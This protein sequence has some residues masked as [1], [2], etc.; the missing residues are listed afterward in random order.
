[1]RMH[2]PAVFVVAGA[3]SLLVHRAESLLRW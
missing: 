2:Y 3:A 1:M